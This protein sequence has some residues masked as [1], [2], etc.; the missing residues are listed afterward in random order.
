M[1]EVRIVGLE[2]TMRDVSPAEFGRR[3]HDGFHAAGLVIEGAAKG[4]VA[5]HHYTG[6]FEQRIHT[7]TTGHNLGDIKT[8]VGVIGVP[9]ARSLTYGWP[10]GS[11]PNISKIADWVVRRIENASV[12]VSRTSK[13]LLRVKPGAGGLKGAA[14]E[15]NVKHIAFVIARAISRRG[16]TFGTGTGGQKLDTFS[17]AFEDNKVLIKTTIVRFMTK[18]GTIF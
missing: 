15:G 13:G 18:K 6:R 8:V 11:F 2:K 3:T 16:F 14:G 7:V 9:E 17:K 4:I 1:V 12:S 10:V 5:P